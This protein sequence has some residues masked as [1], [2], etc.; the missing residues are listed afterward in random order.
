MRKKGDPIMSKNTKYLDLY[1]RME[2]AIKSSGKYNS[3][4]EYE[5]SL[6]TN[7]EKQ[8]KL[9]MCRMMRNYMEHENIT[10]VEASDAMIEFVEK[11][12]IDFDEENIP[13]KKKMFNVKNSIQETDLIVVAADYMTK[14]KLDT[15]PI[16]NK[17]DFSIGVIT[18]ESIVKYLAA[19]DFTKAKKVSAVL[20]KHQFGFVNENA[21]MSQVRP[22][23]SEHK[24]VY[25]VLNDSKKVVGWII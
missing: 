17:D 15:I 14:K 9:R 3:V 12:S 5:D 11:L 8:N 4:K 13:V 16:F 21:P 2:S 7:S 18:Y 6:E 22:L 24:K 10:F 25:L 20:S 23:L 1:R 19:G